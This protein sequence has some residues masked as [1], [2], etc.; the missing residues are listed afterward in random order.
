MATKIKKTKITTAI[1]EKAIA[2]DV[3]AEKHVRVGEG[4]NEIDLVIKQ[5][6]SLQD[7]ANMVESI[8][9]MLFTTKNEEIVYAPYFRSFAIGYNVIAYF[10]NL[11]LP[12]SAEKIWEF[13]DRTDFVRFVLSHVDDGYLASIIKEADALADFKK[14][15]LLK[16]SKF[17][18]I[19]DSIGGVIHTIKEKT[20]NFDVESLVGLLRENY[21]QLD[22]QIQ[23][24]MAEL[25]EK[26]LSAE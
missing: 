14:Q 18:E 1:F 23:N 12:S 19:L 11:Q 26:D 10:T 3:P 20:N 9:D 17:D 4:E 13:L 5:S 16:K 25:S 6:L 8:S 21:P 24:M 22:E 2:V 7:R 15:K